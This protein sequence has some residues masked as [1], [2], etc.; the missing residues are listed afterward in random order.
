[1]GISRQRITP[2]RSRQ[3]PRQALWGAS[4]WRCGAARTGNALGRFT[5]A[6]AARFACVA[7]GGRQQ[8]AHR[9]LQPGTSPSPPE[10]FKSRPRHA[11]DRQRIRLSTLRLSTA[12]YRI[13]GRSGCSLRAS[14][15]GKHSRISS[16]MACTPSAIPAS[17]SPAAN[18]CSMRRQIA[19][20]AAAVTRPL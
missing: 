19:S 13:N 14:S 6:A 15:D 4:G 12:R 5:R 11:S 2:A 16:P 1:M 9:P 10:D 7:T 18:R 20:H 17:K 3:V 8:T